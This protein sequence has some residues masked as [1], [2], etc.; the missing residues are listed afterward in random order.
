[1][2][3]L[4]GF[5]TNA[6]VPFHISQTPHLLWKFGSR[7]EDKKNESRLEIFAHLTLSPLEVFYFRETAVMIFLGHFM[8]I[9]YISSTFI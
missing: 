2:M 4:A 3:A 7:S 1:M 6:S 8:V 9:F 5:F